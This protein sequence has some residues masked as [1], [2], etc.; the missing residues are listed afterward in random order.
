MNGEH[1]PRVHPELQARFQAQFSACAS[2]YAFAG[3][4]RPPGPP[5]PDTGGQLILWSYARAS[6]TYQGSFRL[7]ACGYGE[8]AGM[9][10]RSLYEDMAIAHWVKRHPDEAI[11]KLKK[12]ELLTFAD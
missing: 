6:K 9:L 1:P 11:A 4:H 3:A 7:A 2:L 10:N 12:S 8:Q 5:A